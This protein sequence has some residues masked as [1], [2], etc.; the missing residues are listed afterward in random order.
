MRPRILVLTSLAILVA[1]GGALSAYWLWSADRLAARIAAWSDE[2]RARGYE[3]S[4]RGPAI[5]GYPFDLTARF[6][7]PRLASPQG[8]RW[9]GPSVSG[10]A[11]LWNPFTIMLD[12]SGL[13]RM[14]DT[15]SAEARPIEAEGLR[16]TAVVHLQS[17]GRIDRATAEIF[18]LRLRR[19]GEST[20]DPGRSGAGRR[21]RGAVG[22]QRG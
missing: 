15:R 2:Q 11:T 6:E 8:W 16:A 17:S 20:V 21:C 10:R 18:G 14:A 4:Y 3:V 9:Q 19:S 1:A 22:R 12:F 5:G 7:E 13:H